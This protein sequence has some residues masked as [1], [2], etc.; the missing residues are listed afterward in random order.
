M[1][2]NLRFKSLRLRWGSPG[3][4]EE[5]NQDKICG[6][7]R[8]S[9]NIST[10]RRSSSSLP[11]ADILKMIHGIRNFDSVLRFEGFFT[12]CLVKRKWS[13]LG[14]S[15]SSIYPSFHR[16]RNFGSKLPERQ[17]SAENCAEQCISTLSPPD[18]PH[19]TE[20]VSFKMAQINCYLFSK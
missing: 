6:V 11:G 13:L 4:A 17:I 2:Q 7:I 18:D 5:W 1:P 20:T 3:L 10:E 14:S 9:A 16:V 15:I 19:L 12:C 8:T